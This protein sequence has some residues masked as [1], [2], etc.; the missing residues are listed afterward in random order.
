MSLVCLL[1]KPCNWQHVTDVALPTGRVLGLWQCSRC[2]TLSKGRAMFSD[3]LAKLGEPVPDGPP[4]T[5]PAQ[6]TKGDDRA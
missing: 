5:T 4:D 3:A 1:F 6:H 2:K